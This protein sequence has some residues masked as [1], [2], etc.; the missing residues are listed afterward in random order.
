VLLHLRLADT[1]THSYILH[2][3]TYYSLSL[4][5]I[6]ITWRYKTFPVYYMKNI[7]FFAVLTQVI[8][9][10]LQLSRNI[11]QSYLPEFNVY[12]YIHISNVDVSP[13]CRG[14]C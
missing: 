8:S 10:L 12:H 7:L 13:C 2:Y 5:E 11:K 6:P 9:L 4:A 3:L 1:R 14:N